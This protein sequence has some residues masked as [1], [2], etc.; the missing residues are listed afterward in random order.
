VRELKLIGAFTAEIQRYRAH[1][2]IGCFRIAVV[3]FIFGLYALILSRF[4]VEY[5]E[6]LLLITETRSG[7]LTLSRMRNAGITHDF[8]KLSWQS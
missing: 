8:E 4:V 6:V 2:L 1:I 7:S 3:F 5:E